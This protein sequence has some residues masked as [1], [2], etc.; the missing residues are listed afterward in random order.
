MQLKYDV[1]RTVLI[2]GYRLLSNTVK[3]A[4]AGGVAVFSII[5][6]AAFWT[7]PAP[8]SISQFA[9]LVW[10]P[11][12]SGLLDF[13]VVVLLVRFVVLPIRASKIHRQNPLLF[14]EVEIIDDEDG[15]EIKSARSISRYRWSDFLGI[16]ESERI[17][18]LCLSKSVGYPIP[19]HG[20]AAETILQI[21]EQWG[22]KLKRLG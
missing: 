6:I 20:L 10:L 4:I 3:P 18:L 14:G 7:H 11:L 5:A 8:K 17:F 19:K 21:R 1:S 15:V 2:E 12:L 22:R 13:A 9:S 16:R